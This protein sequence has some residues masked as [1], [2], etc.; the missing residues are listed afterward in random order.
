M[1]STCLDTNVSL[2]FSAMAGQKVAARSQS[3]L[4]HGLRRSRV[5]LISS[6]I[7]IR[8]LRVSVSPKVLCHVTG[9]GYA[10]ISALSGRTSAGSGNC[11]TQRLCLGLRPHAL[12]PHAP[13]SLP[14]FLLHTRTW[15]SDRANSVRTL[16]ARQHTAVNAYSH[17]AMSQPTPAPSQRML[18]EAFGTFLIGTWLSVAVFSFELTQI[19][20]YFTLYP[21]SCTSVG[22]NGRRRDRIWTPIMILFMLM[23]NITSTF[24]PLAS[25]YTVRIILGYLDVP[26]SLT[27]MQWLVTNWGNPAQ[28][29][30]LYVLYTSPFSLADQYLARIAYCRSMGFGRSKTCKKNVHFTLTM[31]SFRSRAQSVSV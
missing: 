20:R 29:N 25:A 11:A 18:N 5:P 4:G 14:S 8:H 26:G 1:L 2:A 24:M 22:M 15:L 9:F 7:V 16:Q 23:M 27:N 3:G 28:T 10:S 17:P 6:S 13:T 12:I 21:F 19:Y 30:A 31:I